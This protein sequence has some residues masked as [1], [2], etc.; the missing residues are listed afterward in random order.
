MCLTLFSDRESRQTR[1]YCM[2]QPD[3]KSLK[4]LKILNNLRHTVVKKTRGVVIYNDIGLFL[5]G[6][7]P[8]NVKYV[9]FR[10][11]ILIVRILMI[12]RAERMLVK[13]T[14]HQFFDFFYY[15][16]LWVWLVNKN[17]FINVFF[18]SIRQ[19]ISWNI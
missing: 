14:V 6:S 9:F 10:L 12:L 18:W 16:F 4:I 5:V 8:C 11:P 3:L 1:F 17:M 2:W 19:D 13:R 7:D 15:R